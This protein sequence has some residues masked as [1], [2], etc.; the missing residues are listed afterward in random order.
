MIWLVIAIVGLYGLVIWQVIE[1][2]A[3]NKRTSDILIRVEALLT[4]TETHS[5]L[6]QENKEHLKRT[7]ELM[8]VE[9]TVA[10]KKA[11]AVAKDAKE[12]ITTTIERVP[13]EVVKELHESGTDPF[14]SDSGTKLPQV[15]KQEQ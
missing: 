14:K 13:K 12:E 10:A 15:P 3:Q 8:K 4:A 2:R 1:K 9:T 5:R 7:L 11:E 6:N